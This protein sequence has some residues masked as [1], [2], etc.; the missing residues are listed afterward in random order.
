MKLSEKQKNQIKIFKKALVEKNRFINLF[1]KKAPTTQL[2]ILLD[3]G[4]L[5]G[6]A[7]GVVFNP[8]GDPVLDIGSGNGFPGLLMAILFPKTKFFLCEKKRK[9]AEFLKFIS[10][11]A[12]IFNT[13]VLPQR[14]EDIKITFSIIISQAALPVEKML[15]LLSQILDK[16]GQAFLWQSSNWKAHWPETTNFTP[17]IFK[18]YRINNSEKILLRVKKLRN[19]P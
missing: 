3:Q 12:D 8:P 17:E 7:L 6:Q 5:T 13:K 14:A 9:K 15:K 19:C 2:K 1:S 10:N 18:S 16:K 11:K 4:L